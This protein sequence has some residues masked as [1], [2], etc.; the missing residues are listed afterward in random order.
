M[1][2][3]D[4]EHIVAP[5]LEADVKA[6]YIELRFGGNTN[7]AEMRS[8]DSVIFVHWFKVFFEYVQEWKMLIFA[9]NDADLS[10][11]CNEFKKAYIS[12]QLKLKHNCLGFDNE[13]PQEIKELIESI[14]EVLISLFRST[15]FMEQIHKAN[16]AYAKT[17]ERYKDAYIEATKCS[18]DAIDLKFYLQIS[19]RLDRY[20]SIT[21]LG[22]LLARF[23]K[24]IQKQ[25]WYK[26]TVLLQYYHIVRDST[27]N[28]Y[29]IRFY[30]TCHNAFYNPTIDYAGLVLKQ[31]QAET[32][33]SGELLELSE[34][35][36]TGDKFNPFNFE[37]DDIFPYKEPM[38][39]LDDLSSLP[40]SLTSMKYGKNQICI[41]A[42]GLPY[43]GFRSHVK[44]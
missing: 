10:F 27:R 7:P 43:L 2:V 32:H 12:A 35:S 23:N 11:W 38:N 22:P 18:V 40:D 28:K 8:N 26:S 1:K 24:G 4:I 39:P 19:D 17:I 20:Y 42:K 21:E 16:N 6:L 29:V 30:L 9:T 34:Y 33:Y 5:R 37:D 41:S 44:T 36:N 14:L 3:E 31:W 13:S 15:G 25:A